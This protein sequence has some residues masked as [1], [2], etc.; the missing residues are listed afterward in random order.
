MLRLTG[1]SYYYD[2]DAAAGV[3]YFASHCDICG[4]LFRDRPDPLGT[5]SSATEL[6][7]IHVPVVAVGPIEEFPLPLEP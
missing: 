6:V 4:V 7:D 3:S 1:P 2:R 5:D